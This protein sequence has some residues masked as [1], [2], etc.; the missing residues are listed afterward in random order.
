MHA[1]VILLFCC[2]VVYKI[3]FIKNQK[4]WGKLY[5]II[6]ILIFKFFYF[7]KFTNKNIMQVYDKLWLSLYMVYEGKLLKYAYYSKLLSFHLLL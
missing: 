5:Y 3:N 6:L 1:Y 2:F 7:R 4:C